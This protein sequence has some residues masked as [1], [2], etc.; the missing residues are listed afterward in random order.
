[1]PCTPRRPQASPLYRVLFDHFA[2]L[3]HVHEERYEL[4]HGPL[5]PLLPRDRVI[6]SGGVNPRFIPP[7][8]L[9]G[10]PA[11]LTRCRGKPGNPT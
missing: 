10:P 6:A 3:T 5:R 1:M 11:Q 7:P 9:A 4:T 2:P 8:V